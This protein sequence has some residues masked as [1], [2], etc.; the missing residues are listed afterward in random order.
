MNKQISRMLAVGMALAASAAVYA[1]TSTTLRVDV[2]FAFSASGKMMP[3]GTYLL[4]QEQKVSAVWIK[5]NRSMIA[6]TTGHLAP[7][8]EY[9]QPRLVF[10]CYGSECFLQQIWTGGNSSGVRVR[11]SAREQELAGRNVP[12]K[13]TVIHV[14]LQ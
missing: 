3:A 10:E 14:A 13:L 7:K 6:I 8:S 12:A 11:T 9:E 4:A 5:G 1:Q 2:P